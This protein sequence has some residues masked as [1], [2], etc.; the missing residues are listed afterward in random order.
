MSPLG[1]LWPEPNCSSLSSLPP[2]S[3]GQSGKQPDGHVFDGDGDGFYQTFSL[4]S[5]G[6][7]LKEGRESV[8]MFGQYIPLQYQIAQYLISHPRSDDDEDWE[9]D[10]ND[11]YEEDL[12]ETYWYWTSTYTYRLQNGCHESSAFGF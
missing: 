12:V 10:E 4:L 1:R 9:E 5:R 2:C 8:L 11:N 6:G 3:S 7:N